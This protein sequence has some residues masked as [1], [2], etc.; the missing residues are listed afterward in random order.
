MTIKQVYILG[1]FVSILSE[2]SQNIIKN[3]IIENLRSKYDL[4]I[5]E[6]N[7]MIDFAMSS[8]VEDLDF[9]INIDTLMA[10]FQ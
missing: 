2:R 6:I 3:E 4:T 7:E 9:L 1:S 10:K 8:R 5:F